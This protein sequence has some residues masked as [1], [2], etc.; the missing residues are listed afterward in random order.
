M[1]YY[2]KN[3][4]SQSAFKQFLISPAHYKYYKENQHTTKESHAFKIGRALHTAVLEPGQYYRRYA[5]TPDKI[6]RRYKDGKEAWANFELASFGKTI[7]A[8]KATKESRGDLAHDQVMAMRESIITH[9]ACNKLLTT[10]KSEQ[11]FFWTDERTGI[12]CKGLLDHLYPTGS[13]EVLLIDLKTTRS[14]A[15]LDFARDAKKYGIPLQMAWYARGLRANGLEPTGFVII[16]VEKVPPYI[17]QP[18]EIPG[19]A[20]E[21]ADREITEHLYRF[22]ECEA[23]GHW[24][25]YFDNQQIQTLIL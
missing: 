1:D 12:K 10:G 15:P 16:A 19:E 14:A 20:V 5:V 21:A 25:G 23:R 8:S 2:S 13:N 6:D 4:L 11:A 24:P 7:L 9:G 18:Y 17:C 22:A 3:G